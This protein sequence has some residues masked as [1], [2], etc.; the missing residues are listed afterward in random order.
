[1]K[2]K[3]KKL[4][5]L[6]CC[7]LIFM[8][9]FTVTGFG[10]TSPKCFNLEKI[11]KIFTSSFIEVNSLLN[12]DNWEAV[13]NTNETPF[14]FGHDT[15]MFDN[16][17]QWK[18]E[19]SSD[20]WLVS[21]YQKKELA[22]VIVVKTSKNC[23]DN[24]E[25]D[26]QKKK[27]VSKK[28]P[29]YNIYSFQK[30]MDII[31]STLIN[32]QSYQIIVCNYKQL[33]SVI[34]MQIA[35]NMEYKEI[36][37]EQRYAVRTALLKVDSLRKIEA[38]EPAVLFLTEFLNQPFFDRKE[39]TSEK[40]EVENM[41]EILKKENSVKQFNSHVQL[42]DNAFSKEKYADAKVH[43]LAAQKIDPNS[44]DVLNKLKEI[45]RIESVFEIREDSLFNYSL[46]NKPTSE[47]IQS[48]IFKQLK[49][50]IKSMSAGNVH[51]FYTL[52]TDTM[53]ENRSYYQVN[54]FSLVSPPNYNFQVDTRE[55]LEAFLD[56][57][58]IFSSIPAV[59]VE[60]LLV[61]AATAYQNQA[62][63]KSTLCKLTYPGEKPKISLRQ[64]TRDEKSILKEYFST[65]SSSPKGIYDIDKKI[66]TYK[67]TLFTAMSIKKF[68][69]VGPEAAA[70][71]MLL[72][73]AGSL[74]ATY[75][76]KG[77]GALSSFVIFTGIGTSV[78]LL[79]DKAMKPGKTRDIVK[80]ISYGSFGI[81]GVIYIADVFI[82]LKRGLDNVKNS[83][84]LRMKLNEEPVYIQEFP[85]QF[86]R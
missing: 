9:L 28:I 25:S 63:W 81:S 43:L 57:V 37:Y 26:L 7:S 58:L 46:Y 70:Y 39:L 6:I 76:K 86:E 82:A 69:T 73:G 41:I 74:A 36:L 72:P 83:S 15:V 35:E 30:G 27:I 79:A 61:N 34:L 11:K 8:F 19:L 52:Q 29:D 45:K 44:Q 51:F 48:V 17:A 65:N 68:R 3:S 31:F 13:S 18:L 24:L 38:F 62:S 16:F 21:Q 33:D 40:I 75:G 1:M 49:S 56:S 80:Y 42:A 66:L 14:V 64:F 22:S 12:Q 32:E 59:R 77:W 2:N 60:R 50:Y 53:G 85:P 23:Y 10:Q 78:Y 54:T 4:F 20:K 47:A 67:D 71:S 84:A 5:P 55:N